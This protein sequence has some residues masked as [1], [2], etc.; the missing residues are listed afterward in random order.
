MN[1]L[2]F[3][4]GTAVKSAKFITN[5]NYKTMEAEHPWHKK[6]YITVEPSILSPRIPFLLP[7]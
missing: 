4:G 3:I 5:P 6:G 7:F 1:Q 2:Q